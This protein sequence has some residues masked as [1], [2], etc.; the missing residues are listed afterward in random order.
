M[1]MLPAAAPL[2]LGQDGYGASLLAAALALPAAIFLGFLIWRLGRDRRQSRLLAASLEGETGPRLVLDKE[3]AVLFANQAASVLFGNGARPLVRLA[4][5]TGDEASR[6]EAL[7]LTRLA[8]ARQSGDALM[9]LMTPSG[10]SELF[11]V[12]IDPLSIRGQDYLFVRFE[13]MTART[14]IDIAMRDEIDQMADI[15]D[16]AP[17]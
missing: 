12:H 4:P 14:A 1:A 5:M 13:D 10:S 2:L 17:F 9:Q 3:G 7:R 16:Q 8:E 6:E 11:A 15:V